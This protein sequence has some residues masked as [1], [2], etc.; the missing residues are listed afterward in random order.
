[1]TRDQV[2][3][4][5][6]ESLFEMARYISLF[7]NTLYQY[8]DQT[9]YATEVHALNVIQRRSSTNL[10]QLSQLTHRTKGAISQMITKMEKQG[11]VRKTVNPAN[12]SEILLELTPKGECICKHHQQ[13]KLSVFR[14]YMNAMGEFSDEDFQNANQVLSRIIQITMGKTTK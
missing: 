9:L 1:M 3:G 6:M 8:Y 2:F 5:M 14:M 10:T 11:I 4:E 13:A 12:K 7:D